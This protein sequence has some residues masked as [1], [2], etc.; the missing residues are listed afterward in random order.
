MLKKVCSLRC[1]RDCFW[2][3]FAPTFV[4]VRIFVKKNDGFVPKENDKSA[5]V[6]NWSI[7]S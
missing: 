3:T 2:H 6:A 7:Y 4:A 5:G 1:E